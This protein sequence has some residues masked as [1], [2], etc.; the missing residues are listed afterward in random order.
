MITKAPATRAELVVVVGLL[1][2]HTGL[3]GLSALWHSP[4]MSELPHLPAGLSHWQ[5]GRFDLYR[6]NPPLAR[7]VAA[8]PVKA[9]HPA[10]DWRRYSDDVTR[11]GEREVGFDF[12]KA[13]GPRL[14]WLY[15]LGRWACIPFSWIGA[16][17]CYRWARDLYGVPSG[18]VAMSLWCFCPNII[19]NGSLVMP[20]VPAAALGVAACYTFWRWLKNPTW[21]TT[22]T[23]AVVLGVAELTKTTLALFYP[24]WPVLWIVYRFP[25]RHQR[26]AANWLTELGML[27]ARMVIGIYIINMGYAFEGSFQRLGDYRFTCRA[28]KGWQDEVSRH[29][30]GNRF[31]ESWLSRLPV[32]LPKNYVQ[33]ID[34]Q[35]ADFERGVRSYLRGKWSERGWWYYYLYA[36]AIKV[37]I[38]TWILAFLAV[39]TKLDPGENAPSWRDEML[40]IVPPLL[41]LGFV[42]LQSGFSIHFR[43]VLPIFPFLFIWIS[44]VATAFGIFRERV[45]FRLQAH[46]EGEHGVDTP[47]T[48]NRTPARLVMSAF[49]GIAFACAIGE[50]LAYYPHCLSFFNALAGGPAHGHEHLLDSCMAW[51]QDLLYLKAWYDAHPD[52]RPLYVAAF[53][54]VDPGLAGISFSVP[55]LGPDEPGGATGTDLQRLGPRAGWY[56][57]DVNYLGGSNAVVPDGQGGFARVAETGLSLRYF[58]K[59]R[60]VGRA[61]YSI[62]IYHITTEQA[63]RARRAMG[64]P[65][66]D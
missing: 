20:D 34:I 19:G 5:F 3:L 54:F 42:S 18:L 48:T 25:D 2:A 15:T 16:W 49:A 58:R 12:A 28:L 62:Y 43:Y 9:S 23:S 47:R 51:G 55:P 46:I 63:N 32:P 26:K 66:L 31:S 35:K 13:N 22:M 56:A 41:I 65:E 52:A 4:V 1:L 8:L 45:R 14:F 24:L 60:P 37:P 53:G 50:G 39:R 29:P 30:F 11:R 40:V 44:R 59:F 33:G 36:L 57:I 7:M 10:T 38:G 21:A 17:V 61:G 64:L 6:V 27:V